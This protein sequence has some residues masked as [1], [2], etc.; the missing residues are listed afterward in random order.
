[1]V[2]SGLAEIGWVIRKNQPALKTELD[3]FMK[4][5]YKGTF[6]N[7]MVSRYFKDSKGSRG[8]QKLRA[9]KGVDC[10]PMTIW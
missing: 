7:I 3:A 4:K 8:D 1:V 6:Y 10:R 9:D 5:L 2:R